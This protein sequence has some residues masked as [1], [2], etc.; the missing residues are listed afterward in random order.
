MEG[1][2]IGFGA[3]LGQLDLNR[4]IPEGVNRDPNMVCL[5]WEFTVSTVDQDGEA[6]TSRSAIV[7]KR[8]KGAPHCPTAEE[9]VIDQDHL[10]VL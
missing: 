6:D 5:D 2:A 10:A 1:D 3:K 8:L 7:D 4:L 9:Y